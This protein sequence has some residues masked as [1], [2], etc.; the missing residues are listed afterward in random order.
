[1]FNSEWFVDKHDKDWFQNVKDD[2]HADYCKLC[3]RIFGVDSTGK[4]RAEITHE[5]FLR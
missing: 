1:M 2:K 3:C 4:S 5:R